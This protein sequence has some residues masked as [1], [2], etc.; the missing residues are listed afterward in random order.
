ML[1]SCSAVGI[2][3]PVQCHLYSVTCRM[4]R[5]NITEASIMEE[6]SFSCEKLLADVRVDDKFQPTTLVAHLQLAKK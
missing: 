4:T 6:S 5:E 1:I 2:V 3:S